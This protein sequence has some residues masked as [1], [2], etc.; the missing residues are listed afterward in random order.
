MDIGWHMDANGMATWHGFVL[1]VQYFCIRVTCIIQTKGLV[2]CS[3]MKSKENVK[4][5]KHLVF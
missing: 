4:H 5:S 3:Y 1:L 2:C